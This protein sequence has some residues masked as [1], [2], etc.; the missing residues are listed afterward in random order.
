MNF[1][2]LEY[3]VAVN[4]FSHFAMAAD[5]C[6]VTQPTLSSMVQ[7]LEDE[8]DVKIFER[9][10]KSV[11][12]TTIGLKVIKQAQV[13]INEM[14]RIKEVI[15]DETETTQGTLNIGIVP[16]VAPYVVPNFIF[17]FRQYYPNVV[18]NINEMKSKVLFNELK[19]GT[20]EVGIGVGHQGIPGILE[21]PLFTEKFVLYFSK[22]C[23]NKRYIFTP[24]TLTSEHMWILKEGHCLQEASFSFCKARAMGHHIYEAGSIETLINIVDKNGGYTIIPELHKQ[25][26]R[27]EQL[28]QVKEIEGTTGTYRNVYMYIKE[29][30]VR[31]R[32]L[33]AIGE[34]I[35]RIIP[36]R[37]LD[38]HLQEYGIKL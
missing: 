7:K 12:P 34:T 11:K 23:M 18:L 38:K 36:R 32:M 37:M 16:T 25:F 13:V 2:Q 35:K 27:P 4:K 5:Y 20:I 24:D 8:L 10:N 22:N 31:E 19:I 33:N 28:E 30:Y 29:D 17:D 1:Q 26:L 9:T 3:I 14:K 6:G 21:I 15:A